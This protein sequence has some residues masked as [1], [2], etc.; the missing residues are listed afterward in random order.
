MFKSIRHSLSDRMLGDNILLRHI[1]SRHHGIKARLLKL[2]LWPVNDSVSLDETLKRCTL[3]AD[4]GYYRRLHGLLH[5]SGAEGYPIVRIGRENDGGYVMLDDFPGGVAYSFG[6]AG[7][8]SWDRDMAS[9]GYDLFMYDHTIDGLPEENPRFHWEKLGIADGRTHDDRLKTLEELI[10]RNGHEG[11]RNMILKMDVEGAEWGFLE[12]VS[13]GTLSQFSQI[14]FEFHDMTS[15]EDEDAVLDA[16]RKLNATHQL[17]HLHANNFGNY[18]V[19]GGKNF[20]SVLEASYVL[21]ENYRLE[22]IDDVILPLD[23]DSPNDK[24]YP[25]IEL[26]RWNS[27]FVPSGKITSVV[28]VI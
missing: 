17:I 24:Y 22:E 6:I 20:A 23:I 26:G 10:S 5:I 2:W 4:E 28:R 19:S 14:V 3:T 9:R 11:K 21:R 8:V 12:A 15:P 1:V 16:L 27:E 25:E 7:D 18:V 13:S